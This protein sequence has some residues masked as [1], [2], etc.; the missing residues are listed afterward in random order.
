[1][2]EIMNQKTSYGILELRGNKMAAI[3]PLGLDRAD[4]GGADKIEGKLNHMIYM[5]TGNARTLI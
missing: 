2:N 1:M 4:L 5:N 3:W